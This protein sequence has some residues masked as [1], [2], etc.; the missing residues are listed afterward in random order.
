MRRV[1]QSLMHPLHSLL[2]L[3]YLKTMGKRITYITCTMASRSRPTPTTISAGTESTVRV[4][5]PENLRA[6]TLQ[7]GLMILLRHKLH[8]HMVT[9][10]VNPCVWAKSCYW[11]ILR[12]G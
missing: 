10:Q 8:V 6:W 2:V 1:L 11:Q 4:Q 7:K 9:V 3:R 12:G 5:L